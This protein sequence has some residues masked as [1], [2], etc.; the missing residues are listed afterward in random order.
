[1]IRLYTDNIVQ[2]MAYYTRNLDKFFKNVYGIKLHWYQLMAL[3]MMWRYECIKEVA[4]R[5]IWLR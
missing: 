3:R 5:W 4:K 1:M 2:F